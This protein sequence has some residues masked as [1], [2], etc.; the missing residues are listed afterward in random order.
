MQDG[1]MGFEQALHLMEERDRRHLRFL[2]ASF[3]RPS[4]TP[5]RL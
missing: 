5:E 1:N 2:R 4:E 3:R